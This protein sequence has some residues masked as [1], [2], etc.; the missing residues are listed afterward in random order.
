MASNIRNILVAGATGQQ[1]R[2]FV[3]ALK[4][5]AST[6]DE[7][8]G[9]DSASK[10]TFHILALTRDA[11]SP[12]AKSLAEQSHVT[13]LQGD[14]DKKDSV[15]KVF[16]KAVESHGGV[17]GVFCVLPFPGL[18]VDG[19][20]EEAQGKTLADVAFE[21]KT[22]LFIYSSSERSGEVRDSHQAKESIEQHVRSLGDKGLKWTI[23]RPGFFMENYDGFL[24]SITTTLLGHALKPTT[25]IR[26]VAVEDIGLVAAAVVQNPE[27][28]DSQILTII[29][30]VL[31][32]KEQADAYKR[33]TGRPQPGVPTFLAR[34]ILSLNTHI[35]GL[36]QTLEAMNQ[37]HV[38][39]PVPEVEQQVARAKEAHPGMM[40]FEEW[41]RRKKERPVNDR[42]GNWNQVSLTRLLTG[43]M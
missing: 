30:D 42:K 8:H 34:I 23:L 39:G 20:G 25:K 27:A 5:S 16:E 19:A 43:K 33:A 38:D 14:L 22:S 32:M 31:T 28:Y 11:S 24:G 2:A 41:A 17:W 6:S 18:G 10:P 40:T 37:M 35:R 7:N 36:V 26:L 4:P 1:G 12:A 15:R 3:A 9:P 29:G 13:V 21:F